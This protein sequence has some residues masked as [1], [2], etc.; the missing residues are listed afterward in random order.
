MV[1]DLIADLLTRIRNAQRVGHKTVRVTTSKM[2]KNVLE[3]LKREGFIDTFSQK[4]DREDKF[5]VF[6]VHLKYYG[7]NLPAISTANKVSKS[8]RRIYFGATQ[9]PKV[10]HGLGISI[11]STSQGLMSD[12]EARQRKIGGEVLAYIS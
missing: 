2:S 8:G 1:G 6:E 3:L 7:P 5:D 10:Y 12:K 9:L 4:K 11:V